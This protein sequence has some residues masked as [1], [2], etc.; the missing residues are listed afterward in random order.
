MLACPAIAAG[1]FLRG[2]VPFRWPLPISRCIML[3]MATA[4]GFSRRERALQAVLGCIF[5]LLPKRE[6]EWH[7]GLASG[8]DDEG[9]SSGVREPRRPQPDLPSMSTAYDIE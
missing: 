7:W 6:S 3:L 1:S 9:G 4:L 2:G 8:P 5:R